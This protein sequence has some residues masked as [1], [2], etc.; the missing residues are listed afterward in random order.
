MD[1]L[2]GEGL[3][4]AGL[5]EDEG[6]G[7][8]AG[9]LGGFLP[10]AAHG[11]AVPD[12]SGG[13]LGFEVFQPR[14][15]GEGFH[16]QIGQLA[17]EG[18]E[19]GHVADGGDDPPDVALFVED[20]RAGVQAALAVGV[21]VEHGDGTLLDE[22]AQGDAGFEASLVHGFGHMLA[23]DLLGAQPGDAFHRLVDAQG[24][25]VGVDDPDA[26]VNGVEKDRQFLPG[27]FG[28]PV[29]LIHREFRHCDE[30]HKAAVPG[31][32][33][34]D[35]FPADNVH[36]TPRM[37]GDQL[38]RVGFVPGFLHLVKS[39]SHEPGEQR[40]AVD[41]A[42]GKLNDFSQHIVYIC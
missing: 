19:F 23:D 22:G 15:V 37:V 2:G 30:T 29:D 9:G 35:G 8:G 34:R 7:L 1:G 10:Q 17:L 6:D 41:F 14:L 26:V 3:A 16:L 12:E 38:A 25:A 20:R 31:I 27:Q 32:V 18:F 5:A 39:A 11:R 13:H 40:L 33:Q 42:C 24:D 28:H 4:G 21:V 36:G